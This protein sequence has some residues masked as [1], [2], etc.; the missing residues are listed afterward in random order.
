MSHKIDLSKFNLRTDLA[1]DNNLKNIKSKNY[2]G[3]KIDEITLKKNNSLGKKRGNY[4][5]LTFS[6]I[7]DTDESN[8]VSYVLKNVLDK[9]IKKKENTLIIGLG[10]ELSTPD[11]LGPLT[12]KKILVTNH[13]FKFA[14]VIKG[15]SKVS[16]FA[17]NVM[18]QTGIETSLLIKSV[19]K[20]VKPDLV[21][22]IDSLVSSTTSRLNKTIQIT[23]AGINPGSG[24]G[25]NRGE[26]N[27]K[28]LGIPVIAIGVPTVVSENVIK[29]ETLN[30][31]LKEADLKKITLEE[32]NLMVTTKDID[33]VIEKLAI[34][35][36]NGINMC[37]HK[38]LKN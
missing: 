21:V 29:Y 25:N 23:D 28:T 22:F 1:L 12:L 16:A 15:Y 4:I 36:G 34:T 33:F 20:T 5:T 18:G 14:N 9:L 35:I 37:L 32:T 3:I 26:L 27:S 7:T 24:I 2:K 17:T 31:Y 10:N 30:K 38:A 8:N 13:L 6:D 19:I 11:S